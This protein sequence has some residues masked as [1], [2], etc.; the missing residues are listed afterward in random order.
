MFLYMA[1]ISYWPSQPSSVQGGGCEQGS[2]PVS[3]VQRYLIALHVSPPAV[4]GLKI[5][6]RRLPLFLS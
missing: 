5:C 1:K 3:L 6:E 4:S 2:L